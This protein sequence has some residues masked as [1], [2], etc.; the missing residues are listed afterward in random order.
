MQRQMKPIGWNAGLPVLLHS[1]LQVSLLWDVAYSK[2]LSVIKIL[3][4][5]L[6]HD[7][8]IFLQFLHHLL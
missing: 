2:Q 8:S 4:H 5:L 7:I 1:E 6:F 3:M